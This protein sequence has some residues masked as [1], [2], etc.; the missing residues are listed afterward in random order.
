MTTGDG[1]ESLNGSHSSPSIGE[2]GLEDRTARLIGRLLEVEQRT[3]ELRMRI[4]RL[5][6]DA[7]TQ[8]GTVPQQIHAP[9]LDL[10]ATRYRWPALQEPQGETEPNPYDVRPDDAVIG[11][12]RSGNAFFLRFGLDSP[13]PAFQKAV[14]YLNSLPRTLG[15]APAE[16]EPEVSVIIPVYGELAYTLNCLESLL[17][18]KSRYTAEIIVVDDASPDKSKQHLTSLKHIRY[19]CQPSNCGFIKNTNSG[20]SRARGQ[21]IVLLNN[22]TRVVDGWLDNLIGTFAARPD[23]GL[24]GSKMFYPDCTLQEAGGILWRDGSAWNFGREDDPNRPIYCHLREVDYI[25]GCSMALR[26]ETW[27]ELNGFDTYYQPAYCEDADLCARVGERGLAVLYQPMSRL[28]HYEGKTSGT[29]LNAGVKS[30]QVINSKRLYLRWHYK[31]ASHRPSGI[32]VY[33]ERERKVNSRVLVVD[34]TTPTPDQDAGSVTTLLTLRAYTDSGFKAHFVPQDNF[35]Y[36]PGY[37]DALMAMG[38]EVAYAPYE[39]G[40][41]RYLEKYGALFD[42][43]QV[44]RIGVLERTIEVLR[45]FTPSAPLIFNNMDLHYLRMSRD[46]ETNRDPRLALEAK[47][48]RDHELRLMSLV[49]CCITPST[50]EKSL[51]EEGLP[52]HPIIVWPFMTEFFGT[53]TPFGRRKDICFLGGYN[54]RPNVDAVIFFVREV[55]PL[56]K[57]LLPGV[58][59]LIAG[60]N[61]PREILDLASNDIVVLGMV[62]DLRTLFDRCRVFVS[63]LRFG[64]GVKGKLYSA[65]SYGVPIV[66]TTIGAEGTNLEHGRDL[67]IADTPEDFAART[68]ELYSDRGRWSEFS[69]RGQSR[70]REQHSV[71]MG[72]KVLSDAIALGLSRKLGLP[73]R[74]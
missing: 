43:V 42:V 28:V 6:Q 56:C 73:D 57:R 19:F 44:F 54:H 70:I 8:R 41:E 63:P 48:M 21:Y 1:R 53:S 25:S 40:F 16:G 20:V 45:K 2:E 29:D 59:F 11:A 3:V 62:E 14:S 23:A 71:E 68:A 64:A 74:I 17:L 69:R 18:H 32:D 26:L 37:T 66:T 38:V 58:R 60:A 39:L 13:R 36:L 65:L 22:D 12:V 50:Y 15:V 52:G 5:E 9:S 27:K 46:A 67:F 72:R 55:F 24:V 4:H 30:H 35:L 61:P 31:L 49:D 7:D 51:L 10:G 47:K 33:F 34:A